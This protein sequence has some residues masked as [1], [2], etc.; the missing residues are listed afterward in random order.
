M[1]VANRPEA[2]GPQRFLL[3]MAVSVCR[4]VAAYRKVRCSGGNSPTQVTDDDHADTK[5]DSRRPAQRQCPVP[6]GV[7]AGGCALAVGAG[8]GNLH[9]GCRTGGVS[10]TNGKWQPDAGLCSRGKPGRADRT[11]GRTP[12]DNAVRCAGLAAPRCWQALGGC[13]SGAGQGQCGNRQS[14]A[15]FSSSL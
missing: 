10:R 6:G 1:T 5:D 8:C 3:R 13:G 9:K 7:H 12:C 4:Y 15:V 14:V 11:Q 2:A